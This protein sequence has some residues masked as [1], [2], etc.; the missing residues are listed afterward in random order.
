MVWEAHHLDEELVDLVNDI[1]ELF[2]AN[3]FSDVGIGV[4]SVAAQNVFLGGRGGEDNDG[5]VAQLRIG[6]DLFKQLVAVVFRQGSSR[7]DQIRPWRALM[8]TALVKV[9]ET[10]LSIVGN[11]QGVLNL[12][13]FEGFPSDEYVSGIIF[14]EQD[15]DSAEIRCH[16]WAPSAA[17]MRVSSLAAVIGKVNQ[18]RV[19]LLSLVWIPMLPPCNSTIFLQSASP[20]PVPV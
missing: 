8:R 10:F 19:P 15:V 3:G 4:Q 12:V 14:D 6:F 1:H 2:E 11:T 16:Q 13:V 7:A 20:I 18:N 9:I 5:D 17:P